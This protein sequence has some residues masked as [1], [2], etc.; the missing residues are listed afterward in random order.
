MST[1]ANPATP[2]TVTPVVAPVTAPTP[3]A[4][5]MASGDSSRTLSGYGHLPMLTMENYQKWQMAVKA[6]LTP[7]N[8]VRVL[9]RTRD[10][11]GTLVDPVRP[12]D[13]AELQAWETSEGIAM[14]LVAGT[15]YDLHADL[16]SEHEGGRVLDLWKA[17]EGQHVQNDASLR[18][19]AWNLL[20]AH[21]MR[22]DD[23]HIQYWRRGADIKARI[24]RITPASLTG[25]QVIEEIWLFAQVSGLR[26]D[27]P[28]RHHYISHP[29]PSANEVYAAF[30]RTA[31]DKKTKE[32]I[33]TANAAYSPICFRC[34]QPGHIAK[35]CPH[36]EA[37]DKLVSQRLTPN[38]TSSKRKWNKA[39]GQQGGTP[40][41]ANAATTST[42]DNLSN[43][44]SMPTPGQE[45]AGVASSLLSSRSP[46]TD[47]WL[48]DSG[49]SS[50][51]T[52]NRSAFL[53]L[54][55]D[56][57]A[58]RLADGRVIHSEGVGSIRFLSDCGYIITIHNVLFVPPLAASL[59]ASNRFAREHRDAYSES[60]EFPLRR[61]TNRRSGAVEFTATIHP[62]DLAY[63]NWK[64][65]HSIESA[66]ISMAELHSRLN[67]M[68]CSAIRRLVR[69][70]SLTGLPRNIVSDS[71][72]EF[73]EDCVNGK[74]TRAPHTKLAVRAQRP[75]YRVFSDVHGPLPIRSRRGHVYWVSFIDDHSRFPAIYFLAKKSDVFDAFRKYK[76]WSE[77]ITGRRIGILRD[78]KGGE[79]IG[80]DFDDFLVGAGIRR[81]HSVR[82]TPQQLGV[83]ERMN[84]SI[85]EGITTLLS[86]SGLGRA[87]WE[88]AATHW[89][90]T[91]IRIPSSATA[92]LTPFELFYG[93]KPDA[94]AL[95]PF[96]CLAY[97]HLQKDQR[98]ALAPHAAQS[99]FIGYPP[100]YK[101]W[102]FWCPQTRKEVISD[103]AVFRESVFPFRKPGLSGLDTSVDPLP[104]RVETN[105][106]PDAS[107]LAPSEP[108]I[109]FVPI[110]M[111]Q[112]PAEPIPPMIVPPPAPIPIPA[113]PNPLPDHDPAHLVVRVRHPPPIA[114]MQ[115]PD[116][117]ELP[118]PDGVVERPR[119]PP[120]VRSL[121]DNYEHH[122]LNEAPLPGKRPSRARQPGA[123]AEANSAMTAA[124]DVAIPIVDAIECAF[125]TSQSMEPKT[126]AEAL[127]RPDAESWI[128]AALAEIE[129]H[130]EN[131]TWK[132]A[133]LPP[134]KRA[135]GSRWVFKVK[136]K[137]D[138]SID[139]YKGRIVAQGFSQVRGIHYNEIFASTARMA[140]MR[141]VIA[142]AAVE[143]L[144]LDS[145]D[146]STAFLN[147]EIDAEIYMRIPEG[148][149]VDGDPAPGEDPKRWVV[150]LLKGL[151]GIKQGPRIWSLKLHSVLTGIGFERTDCDHSV[152]VYRRGDVRILMPIHVDDLLLAS[153]SR[154]ALQ[155]VKT[156]L[157]SHFKLHDQ[158]PATSI[159][160]MKIVRD[161]TARSI[162]LSQPGYIRSILEDFHMSDCNPALTPMEERARLSVSMSPRT[163]EE[164]L[165]MRT[166]PYRELVGKLLYLAVATR[167][168][169]AYA[170]GVLCRFVENPGQ[171]H[172][173]AAKRMLR[174]L[175]GTIDLSLV[176]SRSTS[177]DLFTTFSDADLSGNPDNGRS[178][179]G[180]AVCIGGGAVQWGSRLQPHV[181]LSSTESEYTTVS[182]VGCEVIWM[183]YLLSELG[184]DISR[185]SP[186]L[187]DNA[188]AIQVA[189][190]PEHQSTMKHV[191]RA[192][193]WIRDHVEQGNITVSHVP[194]VDNPADIFTKPLGRVKFSKFR[195][196]LGLRV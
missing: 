105:R 102:K 52:S 70:G 175:K 143:D 17:I 179:G 119:T 185:P 10:V 63:L 19:Q 111:P 137:P 151:Y 28:L 112:P 39:R 26:P 187:V 104:P 108:V 126:L 12:T 78:D 178:T 167:P 75:L 91:K 73:C 92:P 132:L 124:D 159:L 173:D 165:G 23:D 186:I 168:D 42:T 98:P 194:G 13:A 135:I 35:A 22:P 65:V 146:V 79:Y 156:E 183:R 9:A 125:I 96:G 18:H 123:L 161:R 134:G 128:S 103:S 11:T 83:A 54:K 7:Y 172:W 88:D 152:Y 113:P 182:K 20:F 163:P 193:H 129:A 48:V 130:V 6:F 127:T 74:L 30:H 93:R 139:K 59:F 171:D 58:I 176:Y 24:D 90:H 67:H 100:D 133:Q 121:M 76:A 116:N 89:L 47:H 16:I 170:V 49:A 190:H 61:W 37:L 149:S 110:A 38:A 87:W 66:N 3:V 142:M 27:D 158:G 169:I 14:G 101:G 138:G 174:Y 43:N 162:S 41:N 64:P 109:S 81:E 55:P 153:N 68:P 2:N 29:I 196:M 36:A 154:Q 160:G 131:G 5:P 122:P 69:T 141:A 86:Q 46:R 177:P 107:I 15:A 25:R 51:M 120:A 189:K 33:E 144:E 97:V 40:T 77:N 114:A 166:V 84:R 180:F 34:L 147:G 192:Y 184:Y 57:R 136:R 155:S 150:Q 72:G 4:T 195:E 106:P 62:S 145:V 85:A 56:R 115:E 21:Q 95:R 50:S 60:V 82:D 1:S 164:K 71:E 188:S 157:G 99:I 181:S 80:K 32:Q 117:P 140:A 94:S 44:A 118:G 45:S 53:N 31:T 191:H 8:H 148:L